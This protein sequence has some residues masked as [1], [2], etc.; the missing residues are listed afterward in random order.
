MPVTLCTTAVLRSLVDAEKVDGV[1][2][3]S[4][5]TVVAAVEA[6]R[7]EALSLGSVRLLPVA[8]ATSDVV[9]QELLNRL[10]ALETVVGDL[11]EE[12]RRARAERDQQVAVLED[13][14]ARL[15]VALH[16]MV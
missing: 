16:Q 15:Q 11:Q 12:G 7:R 8:E 10:E 2:R 13:R 3:V 1:W 5:A 9:A 14:C 4:G 6:K